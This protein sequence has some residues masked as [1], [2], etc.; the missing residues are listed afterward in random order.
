MILN[1]LIYLLQ[2]LVETETHGADF[3]SKVHVAE[4][5]LNRIDNERWPNTLTEVVTQS[6]QFAYG[7]TTITES[8]ERAVEYAFMF[9]DET[10]GALSFHSNAKTDTF[11]RYVFYMSDGS[12]NFYGEK[13]ESD[14]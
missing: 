11:G 1:I 12:H 3:M 13:K 6:N 8:T 4:V 7:R 10:G 9:E 5:V 2:R 14:E